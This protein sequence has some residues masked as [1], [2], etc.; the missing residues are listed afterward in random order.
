MNFVDGVVLDVLVFRNPLVFDF[1]VKVVDV[2]SHEADLLPSCP[3][4]LNYL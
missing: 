4:I 1:S 2:L 3:Q